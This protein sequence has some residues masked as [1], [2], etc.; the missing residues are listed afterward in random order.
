MHLAIAAAPDRIATQRLLT[1]LAVDL[2]AKDAQLTAMVSNGNTV[3]AG[4][5]EWFDRAAH[6]LLAGRDAY[7]AL[8]P[9]QASIIA[10]M[11]EELID[12]GQN[13]GRIATAQEE[14]STLAYGWRNALDDAIAVTRQAADTLVG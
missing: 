10:R 11:G 12:L 2:S 7:A 13:G 14:G 8:R 6:R 5:G 1:D 3:G 4:W 9:Q